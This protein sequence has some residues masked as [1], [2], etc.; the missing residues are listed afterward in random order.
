MKVI[1]VGDHKQLPATTFSPNASLTKFSRSLFERLI[2]AGMPKHMLEVQYRMYPPIRKFPSD[3]FYE[4]RITDGD[5]VLN[6]ELEASILSLTKHFSRVVFFDLVKAREEKIDLSKTNY[7]E[8]LFTF[9]LVRTIVT[10]SGNGKYG[11]ST[12]KG[13]I[14]VV[15]PYKG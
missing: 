13:K 7:A 14:G 12:L 15:T 3:A 11:L 6:R 1:L 5:S 4:G 9:N 2:D 8:A 10:L